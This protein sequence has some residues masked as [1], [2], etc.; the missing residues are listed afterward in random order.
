MPKIHPTA[1]VDSDAKVADDAEIGPYCVVAPSVEIGP[2]CVLRENVIVRRYTTLGKRNLIDS[3]TV[4]GGEP[5]DLKWVPE[6]VSYLRIG[7]DNVFREGVTISRASIPGQ[8]TTVGNRTYWM[9]FSHAAHDVAVEDEVILCNSALVSGHST[10]ATQAFLSGHVVIHQFTWVGQGVMSR[11][12]AGVS[13]HVPPFTLFADMNRIAG[14]NTVG[15]RRNEQLTA[16]DRRQIKDAFS[17]TYRAS[18]TP[19]KA[20]EKMDQCTDWGQAAGKF[21]DFLRK[22]ISAKAPYNRGLCPMRRRSG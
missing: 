13:M 2:G 9:A 11:G 4:L 22:V 8:T 19:A 14:L 10:I 18:L 7:D 3:H 1:I 5:Q 6:T 12:N 16:E 21:R 17:L 20:L 15:M